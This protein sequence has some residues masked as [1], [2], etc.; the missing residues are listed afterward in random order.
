MIKKIND[1]ESLLTAIGTMHDSCF[2]TNNIEYN[3]TKNTITINTIEYKYEG[4]LI[5]IETKKI[6]TKHKLVL[7]GIDECELILK[8]KKGFQAVCK[9]YINYADIEKETINIECTF[10]IIK[11]KY[12][13]ICGIFESVPQPDKTKKKPGTVTILFG[14]PFALC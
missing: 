3:P 2:E 1:I 11:L 10:H 8:D 12:S 13:K 5:Q 6:E 14:T 9:D 7:S 4:K